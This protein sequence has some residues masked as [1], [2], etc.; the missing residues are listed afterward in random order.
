MKVEKALNLLG[1]NM[2]RKRVPAD[3][4][5]LWQKALCLYEDFQKKDGMERETKS[6]IASRGWLHRFRN[7]FSLRTLKS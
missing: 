6:F 3:G 5:V 4:N 1:G 2:N 7:R